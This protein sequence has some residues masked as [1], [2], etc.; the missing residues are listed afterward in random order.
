M[1]LVVL[2]K[3]RRTSGKVSKIRNE[4]EHREIYEETEA[5]WGVFLRVGSSI[6]GEGLRTVKKT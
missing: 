5:D 2:S 6:K 4:E 3:Q 1:S